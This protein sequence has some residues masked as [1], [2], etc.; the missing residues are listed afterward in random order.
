MIFKVAIARSI[1][2]NYQ[3]DPQTTKGALKKKQ[4]LSF[5]S[6]LANTIKS[7]SIAR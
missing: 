2:D 6:I 1:F 5:A 7:Q 3:H 4:P